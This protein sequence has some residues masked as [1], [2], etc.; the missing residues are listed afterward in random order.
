MEGEF[1]FI[2]G[3]MRSGSKIYKQALNNH[4][5]VNISTEL[6]YMNPWYKRDFI[7]DTKKLVGD[8]NENKN[9]TLLVDYMYSNKFYGSFFSSIDIPKEKLLKKLIA[10]DRSFE[11]ILKVLLSEQAIVRGKEMIGAKYPLHF[12]YVNKL[13]GWFPNCKV[14]HIVR[15]PRAVFASQLNKYFKKKSLKRKLMFFP[16]MLYCIL[17]SKWSLYVYERNKKNK[18][19]KLFRYEDIVLEPKQYLTKLCKFLCIEFEDDMLKIPVKNSSH[20]INKTGIVTDSLQKWKSVIPGW[21]TVLFKFF[22][23]KEMIRYNWN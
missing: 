10:S 21:S 14:V 8:L 23:H 11:G 22:L 3:C 1:I 2:I 5:K 4:S 9:I 7:R 15:D 20:G 16:T 19:Y 12:S 18:N 13:Y 6:H 17:Q